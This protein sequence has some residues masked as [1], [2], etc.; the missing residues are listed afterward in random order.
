[1]ALDGAGAPSTPLVGRTAELEVLDRAVGEVAV[2]EGRMVVVS[3]LA[4]VGKTRL[5]DESVRLATE[6]GVLVGRGACRDG[7][8]DRPLQPVLDA[9]AVLPGVDH[10]QIA[11][12]MDDFLIDDDRSLNVYSPAR[13][14]PVLDRLVEEVERTAADTAV[15]VVVDDLHWADRATIRALGALANRADQLPILVVGALR[16][17]EAAA[18]HRE[19]VDLL[20][21]SGP[22]FARIE[23]G[24]LDQ[25]GAAQMARSLLGGARLGSRLRSVI[26]TSDGSPLFVSELIEAGVADGSIELADGSAE[27]RADGRPIT[28]ERLVLDRVRTLGEEAW[29]LLT[30]AAVLGT[31][32]APRDL[33]A[34]VDQPMRAVWS[35][36]ASTSRCTKSRE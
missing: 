10:A 34:L 31:E 13:F 2:G 1:M 25:R 3:G 30:L 32:F 12:E 9:L 23:L 35:T 6:R 5:L 21:R 29:E 33:A 17:I 28:F 11:A 8:L 20:Q 24:A 19:L 15:A 18:E 16:P 4:G 36:T 14:I 27:L 7:D 22:D 26:A